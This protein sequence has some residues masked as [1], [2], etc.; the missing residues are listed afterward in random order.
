[1]LEAFAIALHSRIKSL[2]RNLEKF[3]KCLEARD[4]QFTFERHCKPWLSR[5]WCRSS[6]C[7]SNGLLPEVDYITYSWKCTCFIAHSSI[8]NGSKLWTYDNIPAKTYQQA[9]FYQSY[10]QQISRGLAIKK[11]NRGLHCSWGKSWISLHLPEED[12]VP[13]FHWRNSSETCPVI[14]REVCKICH[15]ATHIFGEPL[16]GYESFVLKAVWW[17]RG[18]ERKGEKGPYVTTRET[19]MPTDFMISFCIALFKI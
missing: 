8:E 7:T 12:L 11:E 19:F 2:A 15:C 14:I 10:I 3:F 6:I 4:C 17:R 16:S 13:S 1:M 18:K 5:V 9:M